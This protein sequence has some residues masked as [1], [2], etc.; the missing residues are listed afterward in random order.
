MILRST[1][2]KRRQVV[3]FPW[4]FSEVIY[5]CLL[6]IVLCISWRSDFIIS[7]DTVKTKCQGFQTFINRPPQYFAIFSPDAAPVYLCEYSS[8]FRTFPELT[9][10]DVGREKVLQGGEYTKSISAHREKEWAGGEDSQC[11]ASRNHYE[12]FH[13]ANG[14]KWQVIRPFYP[15]L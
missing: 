12:V 8:T 10:D 5:R 6:I 14:Q 15:L 3:L 1:T 11:G 4:K 2:D 9:Y 13:V 7:V